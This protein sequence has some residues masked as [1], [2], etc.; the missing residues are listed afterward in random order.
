L[1]KTTEKIIY[2]KYTY[3]YNMGIHP[4][5]VLLSESIRTSTYN[6][7]I[8]E[9]K[10]RSPSKGDLLRNRDPLDILRAY[11]RAGAVGISYI[12]EKDRFGE[13]SGYLRR[14][15]MN[16]AFPFLEKTS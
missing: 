9:I 5:R 3:T 10:V 6:P 4:D 8:A 11:E 12:T 16:R 7:V 14:Y 1:I 15:V 13:I 2:L